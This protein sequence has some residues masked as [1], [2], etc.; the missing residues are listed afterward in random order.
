[1][2]MLSRSVRL[3]IRNL[4]HPR[5]EQRPRVV[6]PGPG[7]RMELK[8]AGAEVRE[9]EALDRAVVEGD[10]RH[11]GRVARLHDEAV[12]LARHAHPGPGAVL[13]GAGGAPGARR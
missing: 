9:V 13:Y 4:L 6:R 3:G 2:Q 8:R 7:L 12:V 5:L 1:M 10:V 11:L